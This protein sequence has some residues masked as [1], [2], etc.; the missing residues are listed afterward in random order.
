V[1]CRL[2]CSSGQLSESVIAKRSATKSIEREVTIHRDVLSSLPVSSLALYGSALADDP[3]FSWLFLEDAGDD[4]CMGDSLEDRV[5]AGNWLATMHTS[6]Q[7]NPAAQSL[8]RR[9][10]DWYLGRLETARGRIIDA[11]PNVE[12]HRER[13]G[14]LE[15]LLL[16]LAV[17]ESHWKEVASFCGDLPTTMVH[18]DF[19]PKNL[20]V[21]MRGGRLVLFPLDWETAGWG[22][23][24][25]DLSEKIDFDTYLSSVHPTWPDIHR[26]Q[27]ETLRSYGRVFRILATVEWATVGLDGI[28]L[29]RPLNYLETYKEWLTQAFHDL[30]WSS[31]A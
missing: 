15:S 7:Q 1:I 2:R 13:I 27:W 31:G 25:G 28:W 18:C 10:P 8:P 29:R 6:A 9:G 23:P 30:G 19:S 26:E 21:K 5:L 22:V 11:L 14:I 24:A 20:R 17:I 3:A 12:T 16:R 4:R